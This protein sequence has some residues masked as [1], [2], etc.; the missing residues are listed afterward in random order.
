MMLVDPH[1][2]LPE[3]HRVAQQSS[4]VWRSACSYPECSHNASAD[5]AVPGQTA[6]MSGSG[7]SM[8]QSSVCH[9]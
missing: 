5:S 2:F 6:A 7:V 3:E 1:L 8:L 9:I 4:K